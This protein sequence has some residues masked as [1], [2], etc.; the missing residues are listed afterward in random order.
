MARIKIDLPESFAFTTFIPVRITDINYGGHAGND[1]ILSIIH[2]ARMQFL[3][4]YGYSELEF[5]GVGLIMADVGIEFKSELF[6]GDVVTA[7]VAASGFS[8][9]SFELYY[10][11]EK[12][13]RKAQDVK[14]VLVAVAKTGMVCYDY[15]NKKIVAVPDK[16]LKKLQ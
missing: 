11:L 13:L 7:S 5:D 2:E 15:N 4:S 12:V 3:K 1:T 9:V 10:K 8:K 6:Y 16:A 14:K